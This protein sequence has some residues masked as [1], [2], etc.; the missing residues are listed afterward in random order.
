MVRPGG[1]VDL[2]Y[3]DS[4]TSK[5][6]AFATTVNTRFVQQFQNLA[7]GSS[8]F[9]CP[10]ANGYQDVV[11]S[12]AFTNSGGNPGAIALPRGWGY[13]LLSRV[14]FRYGGSSQ[15]FLSGQQILQ[16]A[17]RKQPN[18]QCGNDILTLGGNYATGADLVGTVRANVVLTLPHNLPSGVGKNH[19]FPSELLTQQ[20]QITVELNNPASIFTNQTGNALPAWT[21]SLSAG[22][23]QIQQVMLNNQ[24]DALSRRVDMSVNAYAYPAEFVQQLVTIPLAN[25]ANSQPVVL[26]GFRAG[27]VKA[28][29]CWLTRT[30]DLSTT[31]GYNPFR[32]YKPLAIQMLYAGEVYA[33]FDLE[34]SSI[35]A[36]VNG[37][38]SPAV[39]NVVVAGAGGAITTTSSLSEWVELPF[40]QPLVD[41]DSHYTL[42]HGKPITNGITNLDI[43]TPSAQADW[44][45]NVSYIYNT[46]ILFSQGTADFVF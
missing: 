33:R 18:K 5:K 2:Y 7:G 19:P 13:A 42:T 38:K 25:T 37:D 15:Y 9:T 23:F 21:S 31:N 40:A 14:S 1:T 41:E 35:W 36:L 32:W 28:I 30:S 34:S 6:Q 16:N 22:Q 17:L 10:P 24:S 20:I 39:D 12:L 44:V 4:E 8:T 3:Y 29:H 45:L 26:T 43:T 46:T 11:L 27:E